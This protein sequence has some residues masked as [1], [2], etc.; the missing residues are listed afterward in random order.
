M[1]RLLD[2]KLEKVLFHVLIALCLVA[3]LLLGPWTGLEAWFK[4]SKWAIL[5][6]PLVLY[7]FP[8]FF[9]LGKWIYFILFSLGQL[10][11]A[12]GLDCIP[13]VFLGEESF[14]NFKFNDQYLEDGLRWGPSFRPLSLA[15]YYLLY[16]ILNGLYV[17]LF[18]ALATIWQSFKD[19]LK[20]EE[21]K[22]E[23]LQMELKYIRQ[24][25][26]PH[27]LFNNLNNLYVLIDED[28]ALAKKTLIQF[29]ELLRYTVYQ[30]QEKL[31]SAARELHYIKNYVYLQQLRSDFNCSIVIPKNGEAQEWKIPP[32]TFFILIENAF[33]HGDLGKNEG[34]FLHIEAHADSVRLLLKVENSVG[35]ITESL[36]QGG[37]GLSSLRKLLRAHFP[38]SHSLELEKI[39]NRF[40]AKL[41]LWKS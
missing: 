2:S 31:V 13:L 21:L 37:F 28:P 15:V 25:Q 22:K 32:F 7:S 8:Q 6:Y 23:K 34:G 40:T 39:E 20:R 19:K 14:L 10:F 35:T 5:I 30:S 38:K 18:L 33:K 26:H 24:Q 12:A 9:K 4:V 29:S 36:E 17:F 41:R 16:V 1:E 3:M 11:V 27:F